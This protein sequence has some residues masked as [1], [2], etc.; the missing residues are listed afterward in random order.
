MERSIKASVR[1][2][3]LKVDIVERAPTPRR[4]RAHLR[5][6]SRAQL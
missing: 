2:L 6:R 5:G 1:Q 4:E 3:V